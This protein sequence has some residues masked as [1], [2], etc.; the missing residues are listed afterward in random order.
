MHF[1]C[2][3]SCHVFTFT[4]C[5]STFAYTHVGCL[6]CYFLSHNVNLMMLVHGV[7]GV[8]VIIVHDVK[9]FTNLSL[10]YVCHRGA[11]TWCTLSCLYMMAKSL[12]FQTLDDCGG[13]TRCK[14]CPCRAFTQFKICHGFTWCK[15][16]H[17]FTNVSWFYT[18]HWYASTWNLSFKIWSHYVPNIHATDQK[19]V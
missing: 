18:C 1:I 3:E 7:K 14:S 17:V 11:H 10:F 19:R 5:K 15:S 8:S 16:C 2:C 4:Q 6:V 12:C 13:F 9:V